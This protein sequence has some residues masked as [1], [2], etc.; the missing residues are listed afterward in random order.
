MERFYKEGTK[1]IDAN[2][3]QT[4]LMDSVIKESHL[5]NDN[6]DS[7]SKKGGDVSK[8]AKE[9]EAATQDFLIAFQN[10]VEMFRNATNGR[11]VKNSNNSSVGTTP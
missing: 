5:K 9:H 4:Y 7:K 3:V 8:A 10:E 6:G 2:E 1:T 11:S